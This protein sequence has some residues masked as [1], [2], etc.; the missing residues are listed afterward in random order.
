MNMLYLK[1][2]L[3]LAVAILSLAEADVLNFVEH[4]SLS[5]TLSLS[6][7]IGNFVKKE[8]KQVSKAS[9]KHWSPFSLGLK[10]MAVDVQQSVPLTLINPANNKQKP[11]VVP[12]NK[13]SGFSWSSCGPAN[14]LVD[15]HNLSITPSPLYFPGKLNFGFDIVFHDSIASDAHVSATL[16][17]QYSTRSGVW[18]KIP[19]IGQIGSCTYNDVCALSQAIVCPDELKHRG[20]PC[21]CPINKG[22]YILPNFSVE[23]DASVFLSGNY[24]AKVVFNK[25]GTGQIA[26]YQVHF[27]IG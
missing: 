5:K 7:K 1:S 12:E 14:Q 11:A 21:T 19:C 18:I 3:I 8:L 27:T 9:L 13:S 24:Q 16:L 26:C 2:L 17:L 20:I 4:S 23:V 10:H 25:T 22:E 15:I 6:K